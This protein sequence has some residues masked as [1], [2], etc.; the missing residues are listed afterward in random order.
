MSDFPTFVAS[1][2]LAYGLGLTVGTCLF[3]LF[4]AINSF[5]E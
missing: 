2:C 4:E 3:V 1:I 5:E